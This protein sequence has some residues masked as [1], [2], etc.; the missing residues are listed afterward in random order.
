MVWGGFFYG[1]GRVVYGLT[2]LLPFRLRV[3]MSHM[4]YVECLVDGSG[5]LVCS[6]RCV[7]SRL[8]GSQ[9][10]VSRRI[11]FRLRVSCLFLKAFGVWGVSQL[12]VN[13]AWS[14]YVDLVIAQDMALDVGAVFTSDSCID[15]LRL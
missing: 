6:F 7:R 10:I 2:T 14:Q 9:D 11:N 13:T 3:H 12:H 8:S 15:S 4:S 1:S 5:W